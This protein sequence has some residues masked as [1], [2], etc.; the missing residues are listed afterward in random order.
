MQRFQQKLRVI[1]IL[2]LLLPSLILLSQKKPL[3][4]EVYEKWNSIPYKC[5][6]P[7]G[8]FVAFTIQPARGDGFLHLF[9]VSDHQVKV[10]PRGVNPAFSDNN[11]V[12]FSVK[13]PYDTLRKLR[14]KKIKE[15]DLPLDSLFILSLTTDN[16][17]R[18]P[19]LYNFKLMEESPLVCF[20]RKFTP[21]DTSSSDRT[22]YHPPKKKTS[23]QL[24]IFESFDKP[25]WFFPY[26][27][28]YATPRLNGPVA[29]VQKLPENDSSG[30]YIFNPLKGQTIKV[31]QKPG[32]IKNLSW[33]ETG[34]LLSF[35]YS[36]DTS[37]RSNICLYLYGVNKN[38]SQLIAD[39]AI[40]SVS[41]ASVSPYYNP[42]FSQ[43][44][45]KLYFAYYYPPEESK[46]DTLHLPEEIA[47]LDIWS[48]SDPLLQSEQLKNLEN[49]K[50]RSYVCMYDIKKE[51]IILAGR[52]TISQISIYMKGNSRY[53]LGSN[54]LP[55]SQ[56]KSWDG[57]YYDYYLIDLQNGKA[58]LIERKVADYVSLSPYGYFYI[59]YH[60]ND[61]C[62]YA[63][64][65]KNNECIPL[66]KGLSACFALE[67]YDMPS[68]PPSYGIAGWATNDEFVL[69]Y[70]KYDIWKIDPKGKQAP[71]NLTR[72]YGRKNK[73]KLRYLK[74][75]PEEIHIDLEKPLLL[76]GYSY[77]DKDIYILTLSPRLKREPSI[78][79]GGKCWI[80]N[81]I[82][83]RNSDTFLFTKE[84]FQ[85]FPDLWYAQ[86]DF[87][88]MEQI[89]QA[90]PQQSEY[91]W[92]T[93]EVVKWISP[94]G[95]SLDGL[96]YKPENF[97][98]TR[99]YPMIVYFY[100]KSSQDLYSYF[101]P[102]PSRSI[103]NPTYLVSNG[104]LVFVPDIVYKSDNPGNDAYDCVMSGVLSLSSSGFV[105]K[106]RIGL[107]GH[108]W[109]G[110]QVAYIITRT[111]LFACA[112]AGAPVANMISAY[113]GIR[114]ESGKSRMIQYERSQSR[115]G[116]S[117]W[118][119]PLKFI[120]NSPL[121]FA[122]NIHTPLLILHND[123]DGAVPW[124][125]GLEL[126]S[127][128]RRL[129]K[130]CWM[131][132][133][134]KEDHNLKEKSWGNRMDLTQRMY[135]FFDHYLKGSPAPQWMKKGIPAIRKSIDNGLKFDEND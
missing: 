50:K 106:D 32:K 112:M 82:K 135:Q 11:Y 72:F 98:S 26:I 37:F 76:A 18:F 23:Y 71:E 20:K 87:N 53:A 3:T 2:T 88:I 86:N 17:L 48:W 126:F 117:L 39:S 116:G 10:F 121:F 103:I 52:D 43:D 56:L 30:L 127:A 108:S 68:P 119:K 132:V 29:F 41:T 92:G 51:K 15:N 100:E 99:Q 97:D 27:E 81:L 131:L 19:H 14:L 54:P 110:Y 1:S 55:Y 94:Q 125:Q 65:L 133:Y 73:L 78:L 22:K 89:S 85:Q 101:S 113:G 115:I 70:D 63:T 74:T 4:H 80:S 9:N 24:G 64:N 8:K 44:G 33:N 129:Q 61:S 83:S 102:L 124:S 6:S 60:S 45:E 21:S 25:C 128:M 118:E 130:P 7:N 123:N 47:R 46:T 69:I 107:Q 104:Y 120:N 95:D 38:E 84:T 90:N 35:S 114:G 67:E 49:E 5:I 109:S 93:V 79:T 122:D 12:I 66:T 105:D 28:D 36:T 16:L 40:L 96:L 134:N 34:T 91:Q 75:N 57:S 13:Q 59:R 77:I 31:F 58:K 62:W 111:D 42:W